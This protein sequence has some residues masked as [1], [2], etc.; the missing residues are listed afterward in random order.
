MSRGA[1]APPAG[2]CLETPSSLRA[3]TQGPGAALFDGFVLAPRRF[4]LQ[5]PQDLF[6][7]DLRRGPAANDERSA[8]GRAGDAAAAA[9]AAAWPRAPGRPLRALA[10]GPRAAADESRPLHAAGHVSPVAPPLPP[11]APPARV[12][13][14][15]AASRG[16][17]REPRGRGPFPAGPAGPGARRLCGKVEADVRSWLAGPKECLIRGGQPAGRGRA[18]V[19]PAPPPCAK[20]EKLGRPS[21]ARGAPCAVWRC[22]GSSPCPCVHYLAN[23]SS[24]QL[25]VTGSGATCE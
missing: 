7:L 22:A 25:S 1:G 10:S 20:P 14:A 16:W 24:G 19:L 5:L 8:R 18:A 23:C 21:P 2:R 4:L 12:R 17:G 6:H 3:L 15:P 9:A 13:C 11:G